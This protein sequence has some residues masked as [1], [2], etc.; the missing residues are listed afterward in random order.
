MAFPDTHSA[1]SA[2]A[3]NISNLSALWL[4]QHDWKASND[5]E[6]WGVIP[7]SIPP[8]LKFCLQEDLELD[9][10][11]APLSKPP[12]ISFWLFP[13]PKELESQVQQ[14]D[15]KSLCAFCGSWQKCLFQ[16]AHPAVPRNLTRWSTS[17]PWQLRIAL[18]QCHSGSSIP[19]NSA[20]K[21]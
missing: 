15:K 18:S 11:R 6:W 19:L 5:N 7:C 12:C 3:R 13:I 20:E 2:L 8:M 17:F 16:P 21:C 4:Y 9:R 14:R 1:M 10:W